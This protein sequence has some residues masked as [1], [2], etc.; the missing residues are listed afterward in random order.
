M[1]TSNLAS[2]VTQLH[3]NLDHYVYNIKLYNLNY[4]LGILIVERADGLFNKFPI[5]YEN[6]TF[7]VPLWKSSDNKWELYSFSIR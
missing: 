6:Q 7:K 1:Q 4:F 2:Q 3:H 5:G